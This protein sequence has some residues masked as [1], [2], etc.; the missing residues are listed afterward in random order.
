[1]GDQIFV[2]FGTRPCVWGV[3]GA[4][5]CRPCMQREQRTEAAYLGNSLELAPDFF[6]SGITPCRQNRVW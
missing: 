4:Q 3:G 6:E 2:Y 1:M 5:W